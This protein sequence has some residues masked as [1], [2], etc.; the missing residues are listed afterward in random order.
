MG[1]HAP[2]NDPVVTTVVSTTEQHCNEP[3]EHTE[4]TAN[5]ATQD[6]CCEIDCD[7]SINGCQSLL[8]SPHNN[9][10]NAAPLS[11]VDH[12]AFILLQSSPSSLFR[13]PILS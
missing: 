8:S 5:L 3:S 9:T 11:P 4:A 6:E 7:Y 13:P 12:Y 1:Q 2:D 10:D